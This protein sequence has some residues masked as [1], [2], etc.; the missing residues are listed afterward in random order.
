MEGQDQLPNSFLQ[1]VLEEIVQDEGLVN[2]HIK[3]ES[4]S[5]KGDNYVSVIYRAIVN[6]QRASDEGT[7]LRQDVVNFIFKCLPESRIRRKEMNSSSY[8]NNEA[9]F[10]SV[11]LP[12]FL[13]FQRERGVPVQDMFCCT[14]KCYRALNTETSIA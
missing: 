6:G 3:I 11:V 4:G 5:S 12:A 2:T 8:F 10:Y 13:S 7:E 14:A 1:K 9:N